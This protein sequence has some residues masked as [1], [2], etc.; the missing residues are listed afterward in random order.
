MPRR[1]ASRNTASGGVMGKAKAAA[2]DRD[3]TCSAPNESLKSRAQVSGDRSS[4]T[5]ADHPAVHLPDGHQLARGAGEE[6]LVGGIDVVAI[7]D[8]LLHLVACPGGQLDND[9]TSD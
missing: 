6:G 3:K 7:E 9:V 4:L 2:G 8:R 5:G 1:G